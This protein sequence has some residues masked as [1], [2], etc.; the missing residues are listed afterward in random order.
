MFRNVF[1]SVYQYSSHILKFKV[2]K[3]GFY[4]Q[5]IKS[6]PSAR[7]VR[8]TRAMLKGNVGDRRKM[9]CIP[10]HQPSDDLA[11]FPSP[12]GGSVRLDLAQ[13]ILAEG[14]VLKFR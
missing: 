9:E 7:N 10:I 3:Q 1:F 2:E 14:P 8:K 13:C 11:I 12:P 4:C 6:H 5:D